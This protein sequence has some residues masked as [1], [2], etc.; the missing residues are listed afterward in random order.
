[1]ANAALT[2]ATGRLHAKQDELKALLDQKPDRNYSPAEEDAIRAK[3]AEMD[4]AGAEVDRL[5]DLD[6]IERDL[7]ARDRHRTEPA[8]PMI[9]PGG[10]AAGLALPEAP[11]SLGERFTDTAAYKDH[12][13][14]GRSS[15]IVDLPQVS[16][17]R[18]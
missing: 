11:K 8:A 1:M 13:A 16:S 3:H 15:F 5:G 12:M 10:G 9:H 18:S 2:D 6:K 4:A 17:R 7:K 14:Q